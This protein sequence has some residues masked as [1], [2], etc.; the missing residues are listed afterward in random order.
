MQVMASVVIA[1]FVEEAMDKHGGKV[2]VW[3]ADELKRDEEL[4]VESDQ[5]WPLL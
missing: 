3:A 1:G 5:S 2:I 4:A